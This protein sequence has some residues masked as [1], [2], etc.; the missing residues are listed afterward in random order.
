MSPGLPS[1][2]DDRVAVDHVQRTYADAVNRRDWAALHTIFEPDAVIALDLVTRPSIEIVGPEALGA[3][4]GPAIERFAFFQFVILN[5]HVDLWPEGDRDRADARLFMCELRAT[6]SDG[7]PGSSAPSG[8]A[9]R[10]DAFGLYRD[11]YVRTA[12]G[13]RIASRRYRSMARFPAGDIFP[14][15]EPLLPD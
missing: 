8:G 13:W 6:R 7:D 4:I 5:S 1:E 12:D 11:R 10:D 15:A 3:F 14:L 2:T 9:V